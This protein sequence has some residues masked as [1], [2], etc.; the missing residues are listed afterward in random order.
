MI[1]IKVVEMKF[2][3]K[4]NLRLIKS[5]FG[6]LMFVYNLKVKLKNFLKL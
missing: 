6:Y 4:W 2:F 3:L 1:E 5:I